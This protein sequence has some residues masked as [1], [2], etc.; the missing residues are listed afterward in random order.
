[1]FHNQ[2]VSN[3]GINPLIS[4]R[5]YGITELCGVLKQYN[6]LITMSDKSI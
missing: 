3:L 1:M 6:K 4:M 2:Y 5:K